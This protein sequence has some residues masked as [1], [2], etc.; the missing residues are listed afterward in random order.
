MKLW[1]SFVKELTIAS[2]GFYFYVEIFMAAI[3]LFVI[4]FV[5]PENFSGKDD[6]YIYLDFPNAQA[7]EMYLDRLMEDADVEVS[8]TPVKLSKKESLPATLYET[9]ESRIYVLDK[10]EDMITAAETKHK[11][12]AAIEMDKDYNIQMTYYTQGN[13]TD[14]FVNLLKI[15]HGED[16][17]ALYDQVE[18]QEVKTISSDFAILTDRENLLPV[19]LAFNGSLMGLFIMAAYVFLDKKEGVIKAFAITSAPVWKYLMSKMLMLTVTSFVTSLILIVPVMGTR[20]N[21]LLVFLLLIP[22][23]FFASALGLLLASYFDDMVKSFGVMYL[24]M[25]GM[26]LPAFAYYIPSWDPLWLKFVPSYYMLYGFREIFIKG[27][28]PFVLLIAL[29]YFVVSALMFMWANM[30]YK[31]TL[32]V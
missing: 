20:I 30:R 1:S 7:E 25:I 19:F 10:K 4:L 26:M 28:T 23:G 13:E 8:D 21:Y 32:S 15:F 3:L 31:R 5:V 2:R 16:D 14:K 17:K 27:D 29:G 22:T 11:L 9:E 12:G 24:L 6:E 18:S